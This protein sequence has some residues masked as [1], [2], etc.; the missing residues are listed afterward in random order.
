[1]YSGIV[2]LLFVVFDHDW[3]PFR[4]AEKKRIFQKDRHAQHYIFLLPVSLCSS[5]VGGGKASTGGVD[6]QTF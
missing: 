2:G 5:T 4:F 3:L 6:K 1:M